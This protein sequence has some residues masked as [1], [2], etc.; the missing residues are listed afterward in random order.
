MIEPLPTAPTSHNALRCGQLTPTS[1]SLLMA[2]EALRAL[3]AEVDA[4]LAEELARH[5]R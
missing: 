3:G 2:A 4:E 1:G 5:A